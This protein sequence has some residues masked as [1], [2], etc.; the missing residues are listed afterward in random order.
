MELCAFQYDIAWEDRERNFALVEAALLSA[1]PGLAP[2]SLVVLPEM[3]SSG[4]S[5]NVAAAAD[6]PAGETEHFLARLARQYHLTVLGGLAR[7]LPDG[8]GANEAVAFAP[9]GSLLC[10]YR[11]IHSF[12]PAGEA[13]AFTAGQ[14]IVTFP[15][16][17]F[18]VCPLICYDLRFPELFRAAAARGTDLF[19]VIANWPDRRHGHWTTLLQARAIENQAFVLGV[20][21]SGADPYFHYAGGSTLT[22][23]HGETLADAG[24]GPGLLRATASPETT[25][26]WRAAF[27]ALRD[28]RTGLFLS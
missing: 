9:D 3:C 24:S 27:P 11:K 14:E 13:E 28:R 18:T 6:T 20:N 7:Q 8:T 5:M 22:S 4:F 12:S 23:P 26:A 16:N 19:C 1:R 10:R 15:W 21:R 17:G 25:T 2:G